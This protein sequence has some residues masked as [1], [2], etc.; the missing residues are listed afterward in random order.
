MSQLLWAV[1]ARGLIEPITLM[2]DNARYQRSAIASGC[3]MT[4]AEMPASLMTLNFQE[5]DDIS[6]LAA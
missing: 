6:F 5:F 3:P 1:A 2:L 4:H